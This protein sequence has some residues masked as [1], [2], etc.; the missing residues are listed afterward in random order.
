MSISITDE[1]AQ[2]AQALLTHM[3]SFE[4][5]DFLLNSIKAADASRLTIDREAV[6]EPDG[7]VR[8]AFT[9]RFHP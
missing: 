2:D 8:S 7:S 9:L 4:F 3:S 6:K 5:K 1:A